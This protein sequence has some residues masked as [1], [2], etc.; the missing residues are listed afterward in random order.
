MADASV[1]TPSL[2]ADT[3]RQTHALALGRAALRL[4]VKARTQRPL[5]TAYHHEALVLTEQETFGA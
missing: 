4:T 5:R 2:A 3:H 1:I